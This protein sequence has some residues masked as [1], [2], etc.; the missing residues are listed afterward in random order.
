MNDGA[1]ASCCQTLYIVAT[2]SCQQYTT[3]AITKP[4]GGMVNHAM[5]R[6]I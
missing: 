4:T 5:K 3:S 6:Y 2:S 1:G